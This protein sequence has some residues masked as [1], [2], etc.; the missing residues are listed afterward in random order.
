VKEFISSNIQIIGICALIAMV[1]VIRIIALV[2]R[3]ND[4]RGQQQKEDLW[5]RTFTRC[6]YAGSFVLKNSEA[7][8]FSSGPMLRAFGT[9]AEGG[10]YEAEDCVAVLRENGKAI[11]AR[12]SG[13]ADSTEKGYFAYILSTADLTGLS[14]D[15][16]S[17]YIAFVR[18]LLSGS[19]VYARENALKALYNLGD[20]EAVAEAIETLS[21]DARVHNEKLLSDGMNSFRG[22]KKALAQALMERFDRYDDHSQSAVI[23]F[24]TV[25][26]FHDWD[27][28]FKERLGSTGISMDQRCDI[29]RL[30]LRVPS[31]DTRLL[32][33]TILR[34]KAKAENWQTAAVAATGLSA[35]PGDEETVSALRYGI[36]SPA[37]DVRRNC[38]S[39]LV[40]LDPPKELLDSIL[41]GGDR[42]AA[43]A[44]RYALD[45]ERKAG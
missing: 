26:D 10:G 12:V 6:R 43:D 38:A 7:A 14:E 2:R 44:L 42:F 20:P 23:T 35:Y 17:G 22:D 37:W 34:E 25:A 18:G 11:T 45:S 24:F 1:L 13:R 40:K 28:Y 4:A 9:L 5:R 36:T 30:I 31:E 33:T 16:K 19:T 15:E 27:G 39:A 8:R 29:L 21:S 41:N 32:L 3:G